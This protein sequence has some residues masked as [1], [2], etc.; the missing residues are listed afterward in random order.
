[1]HNSSG[2]VVNVVV[3]FKV[4]LKFTKLSVSDV[5]TFFKSNIFK[6]S[7]VPCSVAYP[8]FLFSAT[9]TCLPLLFPSGDL[10]QQ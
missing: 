5:D 10:S 3:L 2:F 6:A 4:K 1:M 9:P 7:K 8:S